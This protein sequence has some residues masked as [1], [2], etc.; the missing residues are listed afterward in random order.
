MCLDTIIDS[1]ALVH[2]RYPSVLDMRSGYHSIMID[3][4]DV[5]KSAFVTHCGQYEF[6]RLPFGL[7]TAPITF[8]ILMAAVL[9]GLLYK[10]VIAYL[11]D[12]LIFSETFD[13]HVDDIQAV[14]NRLRAAN[15]RLH[16]QKCHF[17]LAQIKYLGHIV[18]NAGSIK[19]D[20]AKLE[21]IRDYPQPKTLRELRAFLGFTNFYRRYCKGYAKLAA[22]LNRLLQKG[23][24][25]DFD[26]NCEEAFLALRKAMTESPPLDFPDLNQPFYL[27]TDASGS[28]IGFVLEQRS[29]DGKPIIISCGGRSLRRSE[30]NYSITERE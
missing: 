21:A 17:A 7:S 19:C 13:K 18:C 29:A 8:S 11:D 14:F 5:H 30:M 4:S 1:M 2:P 15:L 23:A 25:F 12:I 20:P 28:A 9:R 10:S 3:E 22:P 24:E 6:V 16:P 26:Q 27:T